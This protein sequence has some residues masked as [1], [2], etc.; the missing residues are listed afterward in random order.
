MANNDLSNSENI[1][2]KTDEN[3][4]IYV[5]PNS[6]LVDNQVQ[7]RSVAHEKMVMYVNLEADIIPR[8]TLAADGITDSKSSIRTIAR[9][10]LNFLNNNNG[11]DY[12]STWTDSFVPTDSDTLSAQNLQQNFADETGQSFGIDS[13]SIQVKGANF[14]PQVNINF[15]DVRGKTLFE[16]SDNSPYKAFFHIPWPIFYLTI[17]GYYGKAIRYRLHLV[18]FSSKFNSNTGNFEVTT[19]F[20]GSTYAFMNDI[21]LRAMLN[22]PYMFI[23]TVEGSQSFNEQTGLFEKKA[24][25]SSKGYQILKSVY[26][27]MKQK[28]LIPQDFPV[29]TLREICA[30]AST[31]DKRLEQK[32]FSEVI[33]PEV[34]DGLRSYREEL[35]KFEIQ[36]NGWKNKNLDLTI[37]SDQFVFNSQPTRGYA[38]KSKDKLDLSLVTGSTLNTSLEGIMSGFSEQLKKYQKTFNDKV[39]KGKD[40]IGINTTILSNTLP[41]IDNYYSKLTSDPSKYYILYD[42][43]ISDLQNIKK[44]FFEQNTKIE[45]EIERKM[46]KIIKDPSKGFGFEPTVRNLFAVLLAN[47]EVYVRLL[48]DVHNDSFNV[49]NERKKIIGKFS[50]ESVGESIY[51][52]PEIK[53]TT[54]GEKQRVIAYPGDPELQ[55]KLQSFNGLLWPEVSFVE[56]YIGVSTNVK[57]PLVEKESGVND[58]QYV[59]D[60]NQDES[61]I[62]DVSQLFRTQESLPYSNRTPVS[63]L[64]EIYERAKE[65]T[66][67]DSFNTGTLIELANIEFKTIQEVVGEEL[68]ILDIL[69]NNIKSKDDLLRYMEKLSPY[70]RFENYKESIPTTTYLKDVI[71]RPFKIEQFTDVQT[72][73]SFDLTSYTGLSLNLLNYTPEE[74]RTNIFPFN[75]STYLSYIEKDKFTNEELEFKGVFKVGEKDEFI[76][77]PYDKKA[78]IKSQYNE[79]T[80]TKNM[81]TND[82]TVG[83]NYTNILNTPYFHKQLYNDFT[84]TTSFGKYVGSA[85]LLVNSLPYLDLKDQITFESNGTKLP[86][87]RM[88]SIFR[89]IGGTHFIPYHLIVKW[90]S[91]YHRYKRK[92]LDGVDILNGFTT[93]NTDTT[94][95]NIPGQQFFDVPGLDISDNI[96]QLQ[97]QFVSHNGGRDVGIHPYYDSIYH[98]IIKGYNHFVVSS[99]S[100]SF[101]TNVNNGAIN[102]KYR[103]RENNL[104]YWTQYVDNS[105]F[106]SSDLTY[107]ILPSDGYN[108]NINLKNTNG[109]EPSNFDFSKSE[110]FNFRLIWKTENIEESFS[111]KTFTSPTEYNKKVGGYSFELSNNQEKIYDLIA[112]FSPQILEEFEEIFLQFSSEFVTIEN[113][114]KKFLNIKHDNFQNLLKEIVT[115]SKTPNDG[116]VEETIIKIA[117]EQVKKLVDLSKEICESQNYLKITLGN[118]KELDSYVLDNY[119]NNTKSFGDYNLTTQSGSTRY[120]DL[121]VGENP[122]IGIIYQDFFRIS[123]IALTEENVI[124]FRPLILI[125]GGYIK[126]GEENNRIKFS[127]YLKKNIIDKQTSKLLPGGANNRLDFF[128]LQLIRNFSTLTI[129]RDNSSVNFVDGYNNKQLKVELYNTFKSFNDKWVAGNSLGQRLLF[130][131]FLFLDRANRDIGSKAYLNISKFI[132]L[133]DEKNNKANLYSTVSMLLKDS[134]FDMRALP[135]YVNFY[136]TNISNRSKI[137]PSK[138]VAENL[139]GT[140]LDVDYQES[141]P[142]IIVQYIGPSSKHTADGDK[143]VNKFNDDSFDISN[144]NRNPLIVTLPEIYDIDQLNKSNK[145]VAFEVSFGDQYQNIFKGV[146]L[147][148]TTLKNTSESFVVLENLARSESGSGAYNVDISLFDLYKQA[149]YSCEVTCMGNVMIQPTMYFYLKNI[150]MFRGT[151]WITEVSHN[152]R[153]NNIETSFKGTRIPVAALPDP[154]DS[155]VSS[156]KSLLDKITN[157]ARATVKNAIQSTNTTEQTIST[158]FGNF[159]TDMGDTKINGEE[160]LQT[161]GISE[162]GIPYNGYGNEKYIQKVK[163]KQQDGTT[164]EWFRAKVLRMGMESKIY[165]LT[166]ETHM[167]LLSRLKNTINVNSAGETGLKWLELKGLTNSHYF[168]STKFQFSNSITADKIITGTTEFLN[169]N[170]NISINIKPNYDLDRRVD[171]LNISG[172]VN[173]GPFINGYGIGLSNKLMKDLKIVEGEILYFRIN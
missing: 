50:D 38:L 21:P 115:I 70:E 66:L 149:S 86:P 113:P 76:S 103:P 31:L 156:Y 7:P 28:K 155:F 80:S 166:D 75:S 106:N 58:L 129:E 133:L 159:V 37:F 132:D 26:S 39:K 54:S 146:T 101:E 64:Y 27:E 126:S 104:N 157:S 56:E 19:K 148:Q 78:W 93:S 141:S 60:S 41:P 4:L 161:A 5:D 73:K 3:N 14:I 136:G 83:N 87:I 124:L 100:T 145:V 30:L 10:T 142:K 125:Y 121:Y 163:Y 67:I 59:F 130:E 22:A 65:M 48:K 131:E 79:H 158:S 72:G 88:S 34:L 55:D 151:Y 9:G 170:N 82:L 85:Y 91:I 119:V 81:F 116:T 140:F 95:T 118:P 168:Y 97:G 122:E 33:D 36:I 62:K 143:G 152:I 162:F 25:K 144:R 52:W 42:K 138:K 63:F 12:D 77:T 1:L 29:K 32:I 112:T 109:L 40:A 47:A 43:L 154:E 120:I 117:N 57:D 96:Y 90:G 51:P 98:Q 69:K 111:G 68:D 172:P 45:K 16:S 137:T 92:I 84:K 128:L 139:F 13:I 2:I 169:P 17:K 53:K 11:K 24:L 135:A 18:S 134:G 74:Y 44:V 61:R 167:S 46:N 94:T 114:D 165:T 8:T 173:V 49:A 23:R 147:D 99:G 102:L 150:P 6:V 105:K 20:V 153:N 89:E 15:I 107:T 160:L 35:K 171:Q 123:N 71:V 127:E 110:Q 164:G 108:Q